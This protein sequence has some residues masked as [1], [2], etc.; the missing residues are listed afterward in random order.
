MRLLTTAGLLLLMTGCYDFEGDYGALGFTSDATV[1]WAK[2]TPESALADGTP[3]R[4]TPVSRVGVEDEEALALHARAR[5]DAEALIDGASV[6]LTAWGGTATVVWRGDATDRVR[7]YWRPVADVTLEGALDRHFPN[8]E[9]DG[10]IRVLEG[11][12]AALA[13]VLRDANGALLGYNPD[14]I[15]VIAE[16]GAAA[17]ADSGVIFI[18]AAGD[19]AL[20]L[21]L[22]G[23]EVGALTVAA[24]RPEDVAALRVD[25]HPHDDD[26][27][28]LR[29]SAWDQ[30]GNRLFGAAPAWSDAVDAT[31]DEHADIAGA[32]AG[33]TVT[34]SLGDT[35]GAG[36]TVTLKL[37]TNAG[38]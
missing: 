5:G 15:G 26:A 31:S 37:P 36:T 1:G 35:E 27:F 11:S 30:H 19:G 20:T 2:W 4:V 7:A 22:A 25:A 17:W 34:A 33:A 29:A 28:L 21:T 8:A 14:A 38:D 18:T 10:T 3:V 12:V 24:A 13:P 23:D 32:P 6:R 9:G 16:G